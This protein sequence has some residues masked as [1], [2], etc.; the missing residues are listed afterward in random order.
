MTRLAITQVF[1]DEDYYSLVK[2]KNLNNRPKKY[3]ISYIMDNLN[4]ILESYIK[5]IRTGWLK[6]LK[7]VIDNNKNEIKF[8]KL[9]ISIQF[10]KFFKD[11]FY[12]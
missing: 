10:Y 7:I 8:E 3:I 12:S 1:V 4:K 11:I 5:I 2:V 6:Q 9:P